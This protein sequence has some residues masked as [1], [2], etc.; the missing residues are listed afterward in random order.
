MSQRAIGLLLALFGTL[1]FASKPT[2]IKIAYGFDATTMQIL[3]LRML[4]SAP[5]YAGVLIYFWGKGAPMTRRDIWLSVALGVGSYYLASFLDFYGLMFISAQLERLILFSYPTIVV[6]MTAVATR[7]WPSG[8][9]LASVA[10]TYIGLL[11]IFLQDLATLGEAAFVGALLVFGSAIAYAIFVMGSKSV[12]DRVGSMRFTSIAMLS[13][14]IAVFLHFG[15]ANLIS[16]AAVDFD[17]PWQVWVIGVC[18]AVFATLLSTFMISEAIRL[19]DPVTIAIIGNLSPLATSALAVMFLG[20]AFTIAHGVGF[21]CTAMGVWM[22]AQKAKRP[23][24]S[25]TTA[26][27][28]SPKLDG[29]ARRDVD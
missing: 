9:V 22:I 20:E 11:I 24:I 4:F 16:G 14:S 1:F 17:M 15:A 27:T 25:A 19:L 18:I 29:G 13:A 23:A 3:V 26:N 6:A 7:K 21:A 2:F 28:P 8:R 12:L 5:V 10:L